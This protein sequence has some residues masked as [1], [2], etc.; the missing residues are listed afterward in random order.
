MVQS[1]DL[2][3]NGFSLFCAISLVL[4]GLVGPVCRDEGHAMRAEVRVKV[5]GL[6]EAPAAHPAADP[7]LPLLA[8]FR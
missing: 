2:F 4:Q 8:C 1:R 7:S 3:C 6:V 5:R